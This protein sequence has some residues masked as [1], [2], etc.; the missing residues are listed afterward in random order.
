MHSQLDIIAPYASNHQNRKHVMTAAHPMTIVQFTPFSSLVQP[1]FWHELTSLKIDV[2]KLSDDA[3]P[4]VASY[5]VGRTVKDRESGND[6]ALGCNLTV[7]A[8]ALNA[9]SQ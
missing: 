3:L 6:V 8:G 4:I 2:L 5:A 1:A 9:S 7:G